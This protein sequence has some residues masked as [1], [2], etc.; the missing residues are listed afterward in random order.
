M[1]SLGLPLCMDMYP[2]SSYIILVVFVVVVVVAWYNMI[3]Q[4]ELRAIDYD[5]LEAVDAVDTAGNACPMSTVRCPLSNAS[6]LMHHCP[7]PNVQCLMLN[8]HLLSYHPRTF[9]QITLV[10]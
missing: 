1:F 2:H 10:N 3:L 6:C 8:V 9:E 4:K 5:L 7:M